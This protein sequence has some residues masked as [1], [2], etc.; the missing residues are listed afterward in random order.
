MPTMSTE[1]WHNPR[2]SKSRATLAL[3][4]ERGIAPTVV[5]YLETPPTRERLEEVLA[6]LGLRP[7]DLIRRKEAA[8]GERG[9]SASSTD[10]ELLA[11]MVAEP[12]LIERPIVI[13]PKG[14]ALGRPP[15]DVLCVL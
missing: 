6:L 9:L 15:E 3:L 8:F 13:T 14:A 5:H 2:C 1:I 7:I 11:A 12:R 4:E 10:D